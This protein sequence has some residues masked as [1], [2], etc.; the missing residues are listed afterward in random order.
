M[1]TTEILEGENIHSTYSFSCYYVQ[2]LCYLYKPLLL[3]VVCTAIKGKTVTTNCFATNSVIVPN[4]LQQPKLIF[5]TITM[6]LNAWNSGIL[7]LRAPNVFL[8]FMHLILFLIYIWLTLFFTLFIT[9][10][11]YQLRCMVLPLKDWSWISD[12]TSF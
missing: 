6:K 2:E 3:L 7:C 12:T 11:S 5:S 8:Q 10:S 9:R 1:L 4:N